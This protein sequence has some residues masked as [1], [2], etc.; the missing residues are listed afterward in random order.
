[1]ADAP[2]DTQQPVQIHISVEHGDRLLPATTAAGIANVTTRALN[3]AT[4]GMPFR[5]DLPGESLRAARYEERGFRS[6]LA[7]RASRSRS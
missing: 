7:S 6:W 2:D 3:R 1:M 5:K 4:K